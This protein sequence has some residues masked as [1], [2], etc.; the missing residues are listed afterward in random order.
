MT[1]KNAIASELEK[2]I[3]DAKNRKVADDLMALVTT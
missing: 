2:T 1:D 3:G